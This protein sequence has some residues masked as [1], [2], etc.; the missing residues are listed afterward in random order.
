MT[1]IL[2]SNLELLEDSP[3]KTS[4]V[5]AKPQTPTWGAEG[6][7]VIKELEEDLEKGREGVVDEEE[8]V[9]SAK[10]EPTTLQWPGDR[11][12]EKTTKKGR[13][14][15]EKEDKGRG[16]GDDPEGE[17]RSVRSMCTSLQEGESRTESERGLGLGAER[18]GEEWMEMEREV[19]DPGLCKRG[20]KV[21]V[22]IEV[23]D[24]MNS[25]PEK[26]AQVFNPSVTILHSS[27]A[28]TSPREREASWVVDAEKSPLLVPHGTPPDGYYHHWPVE[29]GSS[30][31]GCDCANREALKVGVSVFTAALIFPLLLWGGYVFLPFDA[32]LLDSAPL[33]LVYTLRCSVFAVVPI[34]LGWLVLGVS[35]MRLGDVKPLCEV[36]A[37][38]VGVHRRY[39]DDSV[40]LFLLYFLQLAVMAPYLS[41]D[42]LKL[43]PLLTIIFAFGRLMYWVAAALGSSIRGFGFGL[44]F[45]PTMAMLG[46]NLYFIVTMDAGGTIFAQDVVHQQDPPPDSRQRFWG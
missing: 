9:S 20:K 18:M 34:I 1:E 29:G 36:E 42:L 31:C 46:A 40:T 2:P 14:L 39:V 45:L 16:K 25:L 12:V 13:A 38:E 5:S 24:G 37:W 17:R 8:M 28:P 41:Q 23:E 7:K 26:A 10:L 22:E 33:R 6:E 35:R 43:V 4:G 44:S 19:Q 30:K 27:S 21:Q 3:S 11:G 15:T 32:P